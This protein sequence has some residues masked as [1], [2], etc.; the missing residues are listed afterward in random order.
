[1]PVWDLLEWLPKTLGPSADFAI[2]GLTTSLFR[3]RSSMTIDVDR[4]EDYF[5]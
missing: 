2:H 5:S 1:M 3:D 4:A